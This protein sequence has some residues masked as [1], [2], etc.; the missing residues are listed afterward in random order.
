MA[1]DSATNN[2]GP[3]DTRLANL[4]EG[5]LCLTVTNAQLVA[6]LSRAERR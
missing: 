2:L 1:P 3:Y 5:L 6:Q 4:K